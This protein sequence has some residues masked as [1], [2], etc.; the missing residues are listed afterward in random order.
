MTEKF[1]VGD[2]VVACVDVG[3]WLTKGKT[4]KVLEVTSDLSSLR[5]VDDYGGKTFFNS[6]RFKKPTAVA[7]T[8]KVV[9]VD[10]A[11]NVHLVKGDVYTVEDLGDDFYTLCGSGFTYFKW[12]FK[13]VEDT[14]PTATPPRTMLPEDSQVRKNIPIVTG[15]LDYFPAAMAA[16][17]AHSKMGND[18]HNPGEPLHHA[19]GKSM[20]HADCIGRH[21]IDR[22]T[23]YIEM[24]G[25]KPVEVRHSVALLWRAAALVQEELEREE[26]APLPRGAKK[27]SK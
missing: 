14:P 4:Y 11:D 22:G 20:D 1:K 25:G 2:D 21:L 15:C 3:D 9:C 27:E 16:L 10:A 6:V 24:V 19:R 18:K 12:R 8:K 17:A 5:V 23:K 7:K 13:D 26:G